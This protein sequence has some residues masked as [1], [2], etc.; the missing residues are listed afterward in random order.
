MRVYQNKGSL[1]C[2]KIRLALAHLGTK[3]ETVWI[4]SVE[5]EGDKAD[6][7]KK[8]PSGLV[9]LLETEDGQ[10]LPESNAILMYLGEGSPLV[11]AGRLEHARVLQW[12]FFEREHL[13]PYVQALKIVALQLKMRHG[14][15]HRK[16]WNQSF[17]DGYH[18]L[19]VMEARLQESPFLAGSSFTMADV[20]IYSYAHVMPEIGYDLA[21]YPATTGW[22]DRCQAQP[23]HIS[24][25]DGVGHHDIMEKLGNAP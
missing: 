13:G 23:G 18:A 3:Y 11:P 14:Y 5:G 25:T 8:N 16:I 7:R 15:L 17:P 22:L 1:N 6:Y 20:G 2:Y 4:S 21:K 12:L 10:L 19:G 24:R 9:P